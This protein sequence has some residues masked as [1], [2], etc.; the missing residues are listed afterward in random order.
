MQFEYLEDIF[1]K[2]KD[3]YTFKDECFRLLF[4]AKHISQEINETTEDN[5]NNDI[6]RAIWGYLPKGRPQKGILVN[7]LIEDEYDK[8]LFFSTVLLL[9]LDS[10]KRNFFIY[11]LIENEVVNFDIQER[12]DNNQP[13][14]RI[15]QIACI[16]LI[17][18]LLIEN[19]SIP[20]DLRKEMF[21]AT[22]GRT[23][24]SLQSN[25]LGALFSCSKFYTSEIERNINS[26]FEFKDGKAINQPY[27]LFLF[28]YY[29]YEYFQCREYFFNEHDG[30]QQ[31]K[32]FKEAAIIQYL[33]WSYDGNVEIIEII[34]R[35]FKILSKKLFSVVGDI[36]DDPYGYHE[37]STDFSS[38][39]KEVMY[40]WA[41]CGQLLC[42]ALANYINKF[43]SD[44]DKS[45]I[46]ENKKILFY[47]CVYSD[48]FIRKTNKKYEKADDVD[49]H[50]NLYLPC[51]SSRL[52]CA[53]DYLSDRTGSKFNIEECVVINDIIYADYKRWVQFEESKNSNTRYLVLLL[54]TLSKTRY[55]YLRQDGCEFRS[56]I[57]NAKKKL[58]DN[59]CKFLPYDHI[60]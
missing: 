47:V 60:N 32:T 4:N 24:Y 35:G 8:F 45:K 36:N 34:L 23:M 14:N 13:I 43:G 59:E 54:K 20:G 39:I 48:Y 27:Y 55:I 21:K 38:N 53:I 46:E 57:E 44:L 17:T 5:L 11:S 1:E 25:Y 19:I 31:N 22:Y 52:I 49:D 37:F 28:G 29:F 42:Y 15:K 40:K 16:Y 26:V 41:I 50:K 3:K 51:G 30:Y 56:E 10:Y 58:S 6:R 33:S 18:N 12:E 2:V 9:S 7:V